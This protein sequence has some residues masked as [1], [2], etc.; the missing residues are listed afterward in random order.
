MARSEDDD[1]RMLVGSAVRQGEDEQAARP[2]RTCRRMQKGGPDL[3]TC[4]CVDYALPCV[5]S[6]KALAPESMECVKV[7]RRRPGALPSAR[8]L[9]LIAIANAL[10][11]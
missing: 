10:L 7:E 11:I 3:Q 6:P 4:H 5:R 2:W 9:H 8:V 1:D